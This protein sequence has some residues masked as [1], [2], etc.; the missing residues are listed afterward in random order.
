VT[1][2]IVTRL[3]AWSTQAAEQGVAEVVDG[4]LAAANEIER[5]RAER[6]EARRELCMMRAPR[7]NAEVA[8]DADFEAYALNRG[9][10]C[11]EIDDEG[12]ADGGSHG[13]QPKQG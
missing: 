10:N 4:L 8:T 5:L 11:F 6:D 2:D 7:N 9:W 1:D 13:E 12:N 3:R